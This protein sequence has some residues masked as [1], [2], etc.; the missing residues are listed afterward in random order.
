MSEGLKSLHV[1]LSSEAY[2]VLSA[3]ADTEEKDNAEM[4]RLILEEAM[5]GRVHV[6]MLKAKRYQ[7]LGFTGILRDLEGSPG[8]TG[9]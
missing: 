8:K 6:L 7:G 4:A 3:I 9:K 1:R 2:K 5:L